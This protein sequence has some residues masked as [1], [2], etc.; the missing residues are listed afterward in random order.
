M[1]MLKPVLF[2]ILTMILI[3]SCTPKEG[4]DVSSGQ[5]ESADEGSPGKGRSASCSITGK[6]TEDQVRVRNLPT[7]NSEI[8]G[9]LDLG[10]EVKVF[11]RTDKKYKV[12]NLEDYWYV[13]K[14]KNGLVGW[15]Y[16]YYI[17]MNEEAMSRLSIHEA[18]YSGE[19]RPGDKKWIGDYSVFRILNKH[20]FSESYIKS[21]QN[22]QFK[23]TLENDFVFSLGFHPD[24]KKTDFFTIHTAKAVKEFEWK[25]DTGYLYKLSF[26]N[27]YVVLVGEHKEG[28]E[29]RTYEIYYSKK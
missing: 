29:T 5:F 26:V 17:S 7:L 8:V 25:N 20:K 15:T 10:E 9:N 3:H 23:I 16:G 24:V 12:Y 6:I 18:D 11:C 2:I 19:I 13:I 1:N 27:N 22:T 4:A 21:L 28:K 14:R